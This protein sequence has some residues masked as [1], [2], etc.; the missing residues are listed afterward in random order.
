MPT[1]WD[2]SLAPARMASLPGLL[3]PAAGTG[4]SAV[5]DPMQSVQRPAPDPQIPVS[6]L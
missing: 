6:N 1:R 4:M 3:T 5:W 2:P